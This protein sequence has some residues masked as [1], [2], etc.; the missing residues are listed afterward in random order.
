MIKGIT[1]RLGSVSVGA[2]GLE[3]STAVILQKWVQLQ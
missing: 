2:I 3:T 1:L